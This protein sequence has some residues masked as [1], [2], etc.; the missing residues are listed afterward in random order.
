MVQDIAQETFGVREATP[1]FRFSV[2][3]TAADKVEVC[4]FLPDGSSYGKH[5]L[6]FSN[7]YWQG[8]V[9]PGRND[10]LYCFALTRGHTTQYLSDPFARNMNQLHRWR[11]QKIWPV[12]VAGLTT[13]EFDWGDDRL[14]RIP[15]PKM[16]VY[17][18]HVKGLTMQFS[19]IPENLRGTYGAIG[20][21][22]LIA[23]LKSLGVTTLE[24]LP[25]QGKSQDPFLASKELTNYWGYNTLAYFAPESEYA[26]NDAVTEFRSMVRELHRAGIE[27]ILD[28]VY[29]HTG[30]GGPTDPAISFRGLAEAVYYRIHEDGSYIDYTHCGNTLNTDHE[31]TRQMVLQSLRYWAEEMHVDGFRFDLAPALFRRQGTVD[32]HHELHQAIV[33]DPVLRE[34]K[35]IAEPWDLG[36]DGYQRGRFPQ[37]WLEWNDNFRDAVRRFWK[38][39]PCAGELLRLMMHQGRPVINFVT[40]HDGF[41]LADLVS[42]EQKHNEANLEENRDGSEHNHSF[43]CGVEGATTDSAVLALRARQVRN[44]LLTLFSARDIPMLLAG[45]ELGNS[46]QGNNNAYCQDNPISWLNWAQADRELLAFVKALHTLRAKLLAVSLP[47]AI[48]APTHNGQAFGIRFDRYLLFLN[49]APENVMFPLH[50]LVV[51]E[52]LHTGRPAQE[53]KISE[54]CYLP[55]KSSVVLEI[56]EQ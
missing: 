44:L 12:P 7:G 56:V 52:V 4:F 26:V 50:G 13:P 35:L 24:L 17:E 32:F 42:Y 27:V 39:E 51:R 45:D 34:R 31:H 48:E 11:T 21:D 1:G 20:H 53:E 43:N 29:N 40:C 18:A 47:Q 54:I 28:V 9:D 5:P 3:A 2:F 8:T 19:D 14:P 33:N 22:R 30:E 36:P 41:T 10:L 16:V 46:Q 49:A 25:V 6:A 37:P 15:I 55:Q 23:H 38:G